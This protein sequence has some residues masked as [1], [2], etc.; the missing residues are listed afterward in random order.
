MWLI[1]NGNVRLG[2]EYRLHS[3]PKTCEVLH[4]YALSV[5]PVLPILI[6]RS[7]ASIGQIELSL[8]LLLRSIVFLQQD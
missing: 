1:A 6:S 5:V 2:A 8:S 3:W 4:K 7:T